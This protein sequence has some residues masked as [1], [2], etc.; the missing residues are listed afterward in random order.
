MLTDGYEQRSLALK[1]ITSLTAEYVARRFGLFP[2]KGQLALDADADMVLVNL[3]ENHELR[4][5]DLFYRHQQSPYVGKLLRGRIVSTLVRGN[6][7]FHE[8][9][10][11]STPIGRLLR[12]AI[13]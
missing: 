5:S 8:G 12:P 11:L 6:T 1:T 7:I 13:L 2:R 3:Q 4:A 9:T 10:F